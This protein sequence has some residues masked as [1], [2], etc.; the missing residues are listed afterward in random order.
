MDEGP[1]RTRLPQEF[2]ALEAGARAALA[3]A[4]GAGGWD[5]GTRAEVLGWVQRHRGLLAAIEG[6]VVTAEAD[7]GTWGL[8]GDRDLAA[9]VGRQTRQGR[10]AG[11]AAVGQAATL[12]A[13]P[14]VAGALVDGPVTAAHL[15]QLTRATGASPRLGEHLASAQG[16]A[17][18][19][20]L[21]G[22]LDAREF[23][24][25]LA[26]QAARLDPASRQRAHD[27]QRAGRYLYL[28]HGPGGTSIKGQLDS[29]AGHVVQRA[30]DAL[31]PQ[32]GA[33]DDRDRGQRQ[34]DAWEQMAKAV[35][36]DPAT[37]PGSRIPAQ[38]TLMISEQTWAALRT[39]K[40]PAANGSTTNGSTTNG[41]ATSSETPGGAASGSGMTGG[42]ASGSAASGGW[43]RGRGSTRDVVSRLAGVEPVTDE[44]GTVLPASR[45]AA[46][47]CDC[48]ITRLVLNA[49][50]VPLDEGRGR[51]LFTAHQR[52]AVVARDGGGCALPG[53]AI[54]A[55][56]TELHHLTWWSRDGRSDLDQAIQLCDGHHH[57]VHDHDV[58]IQRNR[59][60][61]YAFWYPDGRLMCGSPPPD[62][63][64]MA[65]PCPP[66]S[67]R[68]ETPVATCDQPLL[69]PVDATRGMP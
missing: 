22:R 19:V 30:I 52:K 61:S 13:M 67:A 20:S 4:V 38:V 21:A 43:E 16:Q 39:P 45:V 51:R 62:T 41:S 60:G 37:T 50:G 27:E 36:D 10:G 18:V 56:Y 46:A 15:A 40:P 57:Q 47:L 12:E 24:K 55:R 59:D 66:R 7:A 34:A 53:C 14:V 44:D 63:W 48:E 8:R 17:Q 35:L 3:A 69:W 28:A 26:Q 1:S 6:K 42:A 33:D 9:F 68:N 5:A 58:R 32:P 65:E 29:V 2:V 11:F 25:A 31:C 49:Q 64:A 54:P 23:G